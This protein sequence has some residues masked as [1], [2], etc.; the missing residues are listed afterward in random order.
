RPARALSGPPPARAERELPQRRRDQRL[1]QGRL[2]RHRRVVPGRQRRPAAPDGAE[3]LTPL[4]LQ[5]LLQ[6]RAFAA[7]PPPAK[8]G[9]SWEGVSTVRIDPKDTPPTPALPSQGREQRARG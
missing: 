6:P 5:E 8:A 1:P 4:S 7:A 9:G 3:A 2:R